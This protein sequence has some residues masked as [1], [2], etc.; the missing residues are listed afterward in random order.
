MLVVGRLYG[1]THGT[2]LLM[3]SSLVLCIASASAVV[4]PV[5][6]TTARESVEREP[7]KGL[8][9]PSRSQGDGDSLESVKDYLRKLP[10]ADR[11][12]IFPNASQD[13]LAIA[14]VSGSGRRFV[15]VFSTKA[16]FGEVRAFYR[17]RVAALK[18]PSK[19]VEKRLSFTY[20]CTGVVVAADFGRS[21]GLITI[22]GGPLDGEKPPPN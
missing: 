8:S 6:T 14:S 10:G 4:F 1:L 13:S 18:G 20:T 5:P 9:S 7:A 17:K 12:W 11:D 16:R 2:V 21:P 3:I 19:S 22:M 15:A